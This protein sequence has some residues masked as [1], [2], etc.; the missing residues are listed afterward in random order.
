MQSKLKELI[1]EWRDEADAERRAAARGT[2]E[3]VRHIAV[4]GTLDACADELVQVLKDQG[5]EW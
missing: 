2:P 3:A 4:A 5:G 1:K